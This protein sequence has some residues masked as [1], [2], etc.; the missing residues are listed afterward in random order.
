MNS[1][2]EIL[3]MKPFRIYKVRFSV[4]AREPKAA[5]AISLVPM[6]EIASA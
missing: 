2:A 3:E 1:W 5:A 4:I 6:L